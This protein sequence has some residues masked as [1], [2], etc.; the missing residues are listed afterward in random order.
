M[1][2]FVVV[3]RAIVNEAGP[4][5]V[6]EIA[7]DA[8]VSGNV[9]VKGRPSRE[10]SSAD[11]TQTV[12]VMARLLVGRE[13]K[14]SRLNFSTN[15]AL[16]WCFAGVLPSDVGFQGIPV[17]ENLC[18]KLARD[19]LPSSFHP[20]RVGLDVLFQPQFAGECL[21]TIHAFLALATFAANVRSW[22]EAFC[23]I[24]IQPE[25]DTDLSLRAG[26]VCMLRQPL[27]GTQLPFQFH[28]FCCCCSLVFT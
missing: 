21:A 26:S 12:E 11:V 3:E 27:S 23:V 25:P 13:R 10:L 22:V 2:S 1:N 20:S 16:H 9:L 15:V 28:R 7:F 19:A 6:A 18:T 17:H 5:D 24:C 4:T 8:D 14:G